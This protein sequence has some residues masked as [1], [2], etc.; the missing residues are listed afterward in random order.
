MLLISMFSCGFIFGPT[1]I[2]CCTFNAIQS[3]EQ[4]LKSSTNHACLHKLALLN[5]IKCFFIPDLYPFFGFF[6][7]CGGGGEGR[8]RG[9]V[10]MGFGA[11]QRTA[12]LFF[13]LPIIFKGRTIL[14]PCRHDKNASTLFKGTSNYAD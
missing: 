7:F 2:C 3:C 10:D 14:F 4:A 8:R 1:S 13:F 9:R 12:I 5:L 11:I 6:F